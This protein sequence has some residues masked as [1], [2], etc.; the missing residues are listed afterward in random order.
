MVIKK[1]EPYDYNEGKIRLL[2]HNMGYCWGGYLKKKH[3]FIKSSRGYRV[4][5]SI[6]GQIT[7]FIYCEECCYET[8][9]LW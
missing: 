9:W 1:L 3:G 6:S 7:T 2:A 5:P 4:S 8:G